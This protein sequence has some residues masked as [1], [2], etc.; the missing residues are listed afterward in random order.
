[1]NNSIYPCLWF[2]G[3]AKQAA[4]FYC[5]IFN[6][7]KITTDSPLVVNFELRGK[8]FMGLNGGPNFKF[9][10]AIS[11]FAT[12]TGVEAVDEI[13]NKLADGGEALMPLGKYDWSERYGWIKDKFGL[14]W[15]V[16]LDQAEKIVPSFLFTGQQFGR[17]EEAI[18]FY[19]KVFD[20]SAVRNLIQYPQGDANAGKLLFSEFSLCNN[21]FIAMDGPG[22]HKYTFNEAVSLVVDCQNQGEIDYYWDKLTTDGGK[23]V[24]CGWLTDKFGISWQIIPANIGKIMMDPD[25]GPRAMQ[26]VMKMIKIDLAI[27]ENA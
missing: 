22:E 12:A 23:E 15:Q 8:K 4:E 26:E 10:P 27:L 5:S 19:S 7:S 1:M 21:N 17:G 2:D 11:L 14:T 3:N 9:T 20:N 6:N 18:N 16:M 13:Y 25:R 24:Q